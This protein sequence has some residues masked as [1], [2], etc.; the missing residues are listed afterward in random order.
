M[1]KLP[2][3]KL[4]KTFELP[5]IEFKKKIVNRFSPEPSGYLHLGHIKAILINFFLSKK[6]NGE[7]ILRFDDTNCENELFE[8]EKVIKEDIKNLLKISPDRISNTSDYFIKIIQFADILVKNGLAYVDDTNKETIRKE[9]L[10]RISN[11]NRSSSIENN[12]HLWE[13]MKKGIL[14][15]NILRIKINMN[16]NNASLRDPTIFRS[17]ISSHYKTKNDF[18]V[19]P[20][21]D[22]ACPI[23]DHLEGVTHVLRSTEFSERDEQYKIILNLLKL[24]NIFLGSYGKKNFQNV[25]MGKRKIRE[26]NKIFDKL[27][28]KSCQSI[29]ICNNY[30]PLIKFSLMHS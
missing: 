20:T 18:Y 6:Y 23:I 2:N 8:F 3:F 9:R 21:Y 19:Y 17:T 7:F 27:K 4:T 10:E 29:F 22:F 28:S 30:F 13:N 5:F 11:K 26:L 14:Q 25:V 12:D 24:E 15:N 16:S 1:E